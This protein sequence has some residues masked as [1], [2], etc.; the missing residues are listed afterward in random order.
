MFLIILLIQ[1][2]RIA[3]FPFWINLKYFWKY[4]ISSYTFIWATY[5]KRIWTPLGKSEIYMRNYWFLSTW[6]V[7]R[8]GEWQCWPW[9]VQFRSTT[10][11]FYG[12]CSEITNVAGLKD[13]DMGL[14]NTFWH[15]RAYGLH[16]A[17]VMDI[18]SI[19][20]TAAGIN[21][22]QMK[23]LF[24]RTFGQFARW[25]KNPEPLAAF[26]LPCLP[27]CAIESMTS[28][29]IWNYKPAECEK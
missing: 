18:Q 22:G 26:L 15:W 20:Y 7:K 12:N 29:Y 4:N 5:F 17:T 6:K 21:Q 23:Q 11:K 19:L 9:G 14:G 13:S 2:L 16:S 8:E 27:L 3:C 1:Y 28:P 25:S 24:R 10:P